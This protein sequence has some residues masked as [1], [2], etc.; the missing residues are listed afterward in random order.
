MARAK[1]RQKSNVLFYFSLIVVCA[2]L[3]VAL[4]V[5]WPYVVP[6]L[7]GAKKS[8]D[9]FVEQVKKEQRKASMDAAATE[10]LN[11]L[12]DVRQARAKQETQKRFR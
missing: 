4:A 8:A 10:G 12:E 11:I 2:A 9:A 6:Q 1:R 5:A 3:S 7:E